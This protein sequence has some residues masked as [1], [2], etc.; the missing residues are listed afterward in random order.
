[1]PDPTQFGK[2][3]RAVG[4]RYS[5]NYPGGAGNPGNLPAMRLW[6]IWNEPNWPGWLSPQNVY[7][8]Q[9]HQVLPYAPILYRRL[10]YAARR[11]LDG[12]GHSGDFVM[13]G[14]TQPL[15]SDPD[16][17]RTPMRPGMF[18]RQLFCVD[19]RLRPYHGVEAS[20][21]RCD[22]FSRLGPLRFSGYAHHPYTKSAPPTWVD[23][24][25]DSFTLDNI[26]KLPK[27]L[28]AIAART[29]R[30]PRGLPIMVT[31]MGYSTNPPN[32]FRGIPPDTQA[33]WINES[34]WMAYH[35][36]RVYSMTQ[37]EYRDSPPVRTAPVGSRAYWSTFQT[38][39]TFADGTP[40]PSYTA[41]ELPIWV[42]AG[43]SSSGQD[44]IELWA[45]VRFR[46]VYPPGPDR[47][48]FQF[49]PAGSSTWTTITGQLPLSPYGFVDTVLP[50][51]PYAGGG[52]FRAVWGGRVP[53][54]FASSRNAPFP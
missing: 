29:H 48:V 9:L 31:E 10:F 46:K 28:D 17:G 53:P 39:I 34:D 23:G 50:R 13:L 1:M 44:L 5:G 3:M 8:P 14:E 37:F 26:A 45:Q 51:A 40:K 30:L 11:A 41:Y 47:L 32:P 38:G 20:A 22:M 43:H 42:H 4:K 7:S 52:T 54:Y 27:L 36:P 16:N 33:A 19:S 6:S 25:R 49:Q 18:L 35:Q 2:F 15:G 24:S 21:R 12:T